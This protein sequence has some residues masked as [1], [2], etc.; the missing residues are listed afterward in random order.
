MHRVPPGVAC[1]VSEHVR[2]EGINRY[3]GT[4]EFVTL[5]E[6][7][8]ASE[9]LGHRLRTARVSQGMTIGQMTTITRIQEDALR[10]LEA[11]RFDRLPPLVFAKGS[12]RSYARALNLDEEHCVQLFSECSVSFYE[13]RKEQP[14]TFP[15]MQVESAYKFKAK[16]YVIAILLGAFLL[17]VLLR[18][19]LP[20]S[21]NPLG[22][23]TD[24]QDL[25]PQGGAG[26]ASESEPEPIGETNEPADAKTEPVSTLDAFETVAQVSSSL[27]PPE[28]VVFERSSPVRVAGSEDVPLVLELQASEEA[29]VAVRSDD[30]ELR[31][32]LLRKGEHAEWRAHDRFL[33]TLGSAGAVEARLNG[34]R[35]GPFGDVGVVVRN[36]ELRP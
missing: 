14:L 15:R 5:S 18:I 26:A 28:S 4:G 7:D 13:S 16:G 19:S 29:W 12:V 8:A 32:A 17:L 33:L 30:G 11:D 6:Q 3:P 20:P 31:E 23:A 1:S 24:Q 2:R 22:P 10:D 9:S 27:S 35:Q 34:R 21:S 25:A 36:I